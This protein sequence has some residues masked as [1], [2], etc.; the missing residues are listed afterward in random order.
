VSR[1][2]FFAAQQTTYGLRRVCRVLA[3]SKTAF[4]DWAA[5]GGAP[6][7]AELGA[8]PPTPASRRP[9]SRT[10]LLGGCRLRSSLRTFAA[11]RAAAVGKLRG[12]LLALLRAVKLAR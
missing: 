5:R 2:A 9:R 4:Y 1:G 10:T 6:T 8:V 11:D 7:A 3:V 12:P